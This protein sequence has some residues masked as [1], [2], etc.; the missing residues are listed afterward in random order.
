MSSQSHD[1]AKNQMPS[2]TD[3]IHGDFL[4]KSIPQWLVDAAPQRRKAIKDAGT[5]LPDWYLNATPEQRQDL[6]QSFNAS[7]TAQARLDKTM[8]TFKDIDTFAEPLLLKALKDQYAVE[9]DVNTTLMCLRRSL[10]VGVLAVELSSFEFL[11][12]TMLQAA[13]HNFEAWECKPGAYH[14][15]SGFM[16]STA[17][18][19]T[20]APVAVNLTISQFTTLC[21]R[22]D[23]GAKY[24]AY[25]KSFFHPADT[26]VE[27]TLRQDFIA[28]QKAAMRAAAEQALLTKDIEPGDYAMILSVISG[29]NH[30][31]IGDKQVWFHDMG[32]MKHRMTGCVG[33]VI[34]EKYRYNDEVILYI[35]N[36]PAHPLKRY[37]GSRMKQ[38][39]KRL[40]L[41]RDGMEPGATG[42]TSY[43]RFYS[44]FVT[45]DQRPYYFSQFT[46]KS[47]DSPSDFFRSPWITIVEFISPASSLTYIRELPPERPGKMEPVPD[48]Y[49][50]PS[51]V[52]RKGRGI[53]AENVDLWTYLYEQHRDKVIADA[54]SHA[55]S[56]NEVDVKAREAKLAHL[57]QVGLLGVDAPVE[58]VRGFIS[59]FSGTRTLEI[60]SN[61]FTELPIAPGAL[62]ELT[63]LDL[64]NNNI[65]VTTAV[66]NQFNGLLKLEYLN[67][68]NNPLGH[69]D[70]SALTRLKALNLRG[71][72]LNAWPTGAE[73]L[74]KLSWL[75][76]RDNELSSLSQE[77]L[78][79]EDALMKTQLTGNEFSTTGAAA[80]EA[81][82]R[83][84][85]AAK[86]LPEGTLERFAQEAVPAQFPPTETGWSIA[87]HLLSLPE[88]TPVTPGAGGF[89][90][91][92][93]RL[94][95]VMTGEQALKRIQQ[96]RNDGM[97]DVH[98]DAQINTWH[99]T[100]ESLTRQLNGWLYSREMP[101][102]RAIV[103]SQARSLAALRLRDVW[104][105]GLLDGSGG[106]GKELSFN[107][108]VTGDLPELVAQL[109]QVTRLDLSGVRMSAQG[110]N[111]FLNAFP[112]LKSLS[113][114]GNELSALPDAIQ[115]MGQLERL[116]LSGNQFSS[117]GPLYQRQGNERLRW[118]DLRQNILATFDCRPFSHLETLEL[119]YN[120]LTQWPQGALEARHL[121]ALDLTGN[122]ITDVPEA[123]LSGN[124]DELVA[125]TDM[126]D[127]LD[128]SLPTLE[129]IRGYS[130]ANGGG[131]VMGISREELNRR[132]E[133]PLS[134]DGS[135]SEDIS[136]DSDDYDDD[137]D[138]DDRPDA[139]ATVRPVEP[140][141]RPGLDT[142]APALEPWL[143][144]TSTELAALRRDIWRRLAQEDNHERFFQLITLLRD[145]D[146]FRFVR[147]DLTRRLWDVM[148]AAAENTELR[149][150]LF[151]NAETHGTC[152]DGRILTFSELEVRVYVYRA[153]RDIPPGRPLQRGRAL[154]Q[155]SRQLFRLERVET[156]AEAAAQRRDRAEVRLRYRIGLAGG[157]EDGLELPGQPAHMAFDRPIRGQLLADTR[158][159]ILAAERSDALL[160]SMVARDYWTEY[161]QERY[162][163]EISAIEEALGEERL[164]QLSELE[165]RRA[166]GEIADQEYEKDVVELGKQ[167]Q[168]R[169]TQ[170]LIELSRRAIQALQ[171]LAGETEVP[172]TLSPQPGPSRRN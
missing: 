61:G 51:T 143:A 101:M 139:D 95:P 157:W 129:R 34:C 6:N 59:A 171:A 155:L 18:P 42:P 31:W 147:A 63:R 65:A 105:E 145:T 131:S 169:R 74:P 64:H 1:P 126:G 41:N 5:V 37:S 93:Q 87:S 102:R 45:Y 111:G 38:E 32:L 7:A 62:P 107:G 16:V 140:L 122:S 73:K 14:Q 13:L 151:H 94:N 103:S 25:L 97:N 152:I 33:F 116:E 83:R 10:E 153:L 150:L 119:G 154:L 159:S 43:Q 168:T 104:R 141:Y 88:R 146:E 99:Q 48:P 70:V 68:G 90:E 58:Q 84:I 76:L 100:C 78:S 92:L 47:A 114:N 113:I 49:I 120:S 46:Q 39:F 166:N 3:S 156:I 127:N 130:D 123:L 69:L 9:V 108:L 96:L 79:D 22:L 72:T 55:V 11:K 26:R 124:H 170:K 117:L 50:A 81:A 136:D 125:G 149:E 163:D 12:L 2:A 8:S 161:L 134:D 15:T 110:S 57:L 80:L 4:E 19:G 40:F 115:H 172:G 60:T 29:E 54:R 23:I 28:S 71:T 133:D 44:Q 82:R 98:I 128:L 144:N 24:Q 135:G 165:D 36:D 30:P 67:L 137:S 56:S 162:P 86:G 148:D 160:H 20:Y 132:I 21:R 53:W 138:G 121:R 142:A 118:I 164:Q 52:T 66:Q 27:A 17:T 35:P 109:P 89:A 75:D 77:A 167:T 85:E 158:A 112:Q 91:R 106:A